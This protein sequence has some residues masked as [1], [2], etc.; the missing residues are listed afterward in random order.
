MM[1]GVADHATTIAASTAGYCPASTSSLSEVVWS[2]CSRNFCSDLVT[3]LR[4]EPTGLAPPT[5]APSAPFDLR[6]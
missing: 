5:R 4:P 2:A 3:P 6:F 1:F